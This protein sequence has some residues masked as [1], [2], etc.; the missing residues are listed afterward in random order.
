V[1]HREIAVTNL[2]KRFLKENAATTAVE[3]GMLI[4][5]IAITITTALSVLGTTL[6]Q[7]WIQPIVNSLGSAS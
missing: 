1:G 2:L 6:V 4:A 5:M 3:Y 7:Q